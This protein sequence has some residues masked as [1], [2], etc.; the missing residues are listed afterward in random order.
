MRSAIMLLALAV[1]AS[2]MPAQEHHHTDQPATGSSPRLLENLGSYHHRITTRSPRAQRYFDQGLRLSYAFNHE[3]AVL[4]F[5][6]AE[7]LD[8]TCAMCAWGIAYALG[9]NINAPIT[10]DA[11]RTAYRAAM[12]ASRNAAR[13]T[14]AEQALIRAMALRYA[15]QPDGRAVRDSAYAAALAEVAREFATDDEALTLRAEAL[16]DLSPWVYWNADGSPR[17]ATPEILASLETVLR[18]NPDHPG[19]C[20]LYI[21]LVEAVHPERAVACAE[22]LAALMPGAGHIVHM[23]GH[24]YIRVGRWADAIEANRHAVHADQQYFDNPGTT[25]LGLYGQGYAPHNWHFMTFAATMAGQAS[26]AIEA[27]RQTTDAVDAGVARAEP[28]AEAM[29]PTLITTLVRFGRWNDVLAEPLPDTALKFAGAMAWYARG[30]ALASLGR[31]DEAAAAL[32][33]VT[34]LSQAYPVPEMLMAMGVAREALRAEIAWRQNDVDG[35]VRMYR[36]A[37]ELED[38]I[39]YMEPPWWYYPM[40][41][42]YG[43]ALLRAGRPEEAEAAYRQDLVRFPENVWALAGLR[44]S[45]LAQRRSAE[46]EEVGARLARSGRN[47]DIALGASRF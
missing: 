22:R 45:L 9:P 24:I 29:Q 46:A 26:V 35:A 5:A 30:V 8:S 15:A 19:A 6:E 42:A 1:A 31:G 27:A 11:E 14:P 34:R 33:S 44:A 36:H 25:R 3:G 18:R 21:H 7:R 20:H 37:V 41:H 16:M 12:R 2:A 47:A 13:V 10:P 4:A 32:D 28:L 39:S 38:A 40:R 23:P 17:P 43:A